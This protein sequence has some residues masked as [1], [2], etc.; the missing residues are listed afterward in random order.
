MNKFHFFT[1]YDLLQTQSSG[2]AF[3]PAGVVTVDSVDKDAFRITNLHSAGSVPRAYAICDGTICAQIDDNDSS[4]INIILKPSVQ[5]SNCFVPVLY[6]IYKGIKLDSLVNTSTMKISDSSTMQV[7]ESIRNSQ[8]A[9][10]ASFDELNNNSPGTT[11]DKASA[12]SLGL[13]YTASASSPNQVLGTDPID[14]LFYRE[15]VEYQLP[16]VQAG[17]TI[18]Q[19]DSEGFGLEIILES[20]AY[21]PIVSLARTLEN[22]VLVDTLPSTPTQAEQFG[23][24]HD[25]ESCL[26]FMDVAAFYG[27]MYSIKVTATDSSASTDNFQGESA[28]ENLMETFYNK[29]RV[30]LDIRNE[31]D[32]SIDYYGNYGR[33]FEIAYDG[34]STPSADEYYKFGWPIFMIQN[35]DFASISGD[36]QEIIVAL[37]SGDTDENV[38]PILYLQQGNTLNTFGKEV[39]FEKRFISLTLGTFNSANETIIIPS[40]ATLNVIMSCYVKAYYFKEYDVSN[41]LVSSGTVVR[42]SNELDI[43]L[44]LRST[45]KFSKADYS[46]S[47]LCTSIRLIYLNGSKCLANIIRSEDSSTMTFIV[48][49]FYVS[50]KSEIISNNITSKMDLADSLAL[51]FSYVAR[52][53]NIVKGEII[54]EEQDRCFFA[55]TGKKVT[56]YTL[57]INVGRTELEGLLKSQTYLS[58]YPL[59]LSIDSIERQI[60]IT[61]DEKPY[62]KI[63]LSIC[64]FIETSSNSIEVAKSTSS[65]TLI[66]YGNI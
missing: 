58:K 24:W 6:Y 29:N 19:F 32:L 51:S 7:A 20:V 54:N 50:K 41:N 62:I 30:Y 27:S 2:E 5:P 13:H 39:I 66:S 47:T 61:D 52:D 64:G 26:N 48:H 4:L 37:P 55:N 40:H 36:K 1:D 35:S 34:S 21:N 3:G 12:N 25:K 65:L 38:N 49:P 44:P 17:W 46:A 15:N 59:Y 28:Y 11:T 33:D 8:E 9:W 18:G 53:I 10:N 63:V 60:E 57:L 22:F 45:L 43:K 16:N 56:D 23:H 14:L 42:G 31:H